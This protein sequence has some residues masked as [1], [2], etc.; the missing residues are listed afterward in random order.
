M[1]T[2]QN[3]RID[4][5][6][7][8]AEQITELYRQQIKQELLSQWNNILSEQDEIVQE[9]LKDEYIKEQFIKI[10]TERGVKDLQEATELK[11]TLKN[12]GGS[13]NIW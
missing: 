4:L 5:D 9:L 12:H 7:T 13:N 8:A 6:E 2:T 10:L 1:T 3:K 11:G